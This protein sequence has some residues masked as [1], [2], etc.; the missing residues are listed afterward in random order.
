MPAIRAADTLPTRPTLD[1][2][3][4]RLLAS[5]LAAPRDTPKRALLPASAENDSSRRR[6]SPWFQGASGKGGLIIEGQQMERIRPL[7][8]DRTPWAPPAKPEDAIHAWTDGSFRTSAGMGWVITKDPQGRGDAL[9]QDSK[10]L[11]PIQTAFDAEVTA[12]E[13]ALFWYLNNRNTSPSLVIHSDSTSAITRAGHTGAGP[14][15]EH[16]IRIQRWVTAL[17]KA[18]RKRTVDLVWVKGHAGTPGNKRADV[19]AGRAAEKIGTHTTMSLSHIK[20]RISERYRKAK[21]AWHA[22]PAHHGTEEIPP[23]P[24]KKSMLDRARNSIA[25]V[26][27]QIRTGHWRSAVY[28]KRIRKRESDQCWLCEGVDRTPHRMSRAH[29]LTVETPGWPPLG[30]KLVRER[31]RRVSGDC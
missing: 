3:R 4:E 7:P 9:A 24:P 1:R 15:Q 5:V 21:D 10:S 12:I 17:N 31:I 6:L 27:A 23:P 16:A 14:G 18:T 26:A 19:L 22:D 8:R 25:R 29:V 20:L 30:Q 13:G 11:G 2:R 28:L